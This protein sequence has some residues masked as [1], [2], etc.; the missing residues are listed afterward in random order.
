MH[1][2]N[3]IVSSAKAA[4][5]DSLHPYKT[6]NMSHPYVLIQVRLVG[7]KANDTGPLEIIKDVNSIIPDDGI[8][9]DGIRADIIENKILKLT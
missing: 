4:P 9:Q 6:S 8:K 7:Q 1:M 3:A 2:L 5:Q